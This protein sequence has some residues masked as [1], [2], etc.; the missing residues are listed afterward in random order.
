M[1]IS[2]KTWEQALHSQS[3]CNLSGLAHFLVRVLD[4]LG[5]IFESVLTKSGIQWLT[6]DLPMDGKHRYERALAA[7][8][9]TTPPALEARLQLGYASI[10][11]PSCAAR[12]LSAC[13]RTID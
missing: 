13:R 3:A 11:N 12:C 2:E 8:E 10:E 6:L 4:E 7:V 1:P 9:E 5:R